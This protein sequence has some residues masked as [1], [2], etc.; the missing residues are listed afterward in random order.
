MKNLIEQTYEKEAQ[1]FAINEA[2][3]SSNFEKEQVLSNQ[4]ELTLI[5]RSIHSNL[6]KSLQLK[7]A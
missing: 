2:T 7:T 4:E 6:N 1:I 5:K 3:L